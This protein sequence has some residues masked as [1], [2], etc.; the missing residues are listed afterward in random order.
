MKIVDCF[1]HLFYCLGRI[2]LRKLALIAD[3]IEEFPSSCQLCD[4]V[5]FVLTSVST[6]VLGW[7]LLS[8][9]LTRTNRGSARYADG[10]MP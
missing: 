7:L 3:S 8:V 2:L 10:L 9:H 6:I 4:D 5:E 1:K